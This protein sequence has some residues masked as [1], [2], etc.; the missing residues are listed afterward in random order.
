MDLKQIQYFIALFEDGSVTRAAKR[1]NIVQPA[2]SM[3]IAKLEEELNQQLFERSAHGM[4]PTATGRLMY[5]LF[6]PIVRDIAHARQQLLQR[7]EVVTGHVSIGVIA[8]VT[9]SVLADSLSRFHARYPHVEV[10]VADGYSATFIDW[11]SGGQL[12]AALINKPRTRLSLDSQP[13]LDEEMVLVTSATHGPELPPTI[14]LAK[15]PDLELVLPTKRHGLRGV[16][17][18]AAQHE[19]VL[20]APRMEIDVLSTIVKL[21]A[22]TRFATILPRIVIERA[23]GLGTLRAHPILAPRI[24]RHIVRISHPRRPLSAAA[25]ALIE[26]VADELRKVSAATTAVSAASAA[27]ANR[28]AARDS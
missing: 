5:R 4:S 3:Q 8:S 12:D 18:T 23:V 17:E 16:I 9:E 2:L 22:A 24:V 27:S 1:L 20:L 15:L 11:V 25:E 10:T 6:L 21:V 28:R 14:E 7:D 26:I 13:L 19:N